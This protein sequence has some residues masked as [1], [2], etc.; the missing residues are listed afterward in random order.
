MPKILNLT[1]EEKAEKYALKYKKTANLSVQEMADKYDENRKKS[2]VSC[3]KWASENK[4]KVAV[5]SKA[6]Y[7]LHK[8]KYNRNSCIRLK[9]IYDAKKLQ[10]H[11]DSIQGV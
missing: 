8:V 7:E 4:E 6:N 5:I 11:I 1:T 10:E 2:S 3:F 9:K